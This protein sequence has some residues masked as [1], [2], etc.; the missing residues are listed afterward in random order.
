M[1]LLTITQRAS[2]ALGLP[3]PVAVTG[4]TDIN[5]LQLLELA[6]EEGEE[7]SRRSDWPALTRQQTF[8]TTAAAVQAGALP[9]DWDRFIND[10]LFNR[11]TNRKLIGPLSP[12]DW[13]AE[14]ANPSVS[15]VY[16]AFRLRGADFLI[17]PTPPAGQTIAFE[18][19]TN[20]WCQSSG[21]TA[22]SAWAADTDT[23]ILAER[24]FV[25]G[26]VW[27]FRQAKGLEY[28]EALE[29][30]EQEVQKAAGRAPG[31]G[32]LSL[33]TRPLLRPVIYPNVPDGN[34]P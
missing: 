13:Q 32:V 4:S 20:Q 22:Q 6:Q 31:A 9:S 23:A 25:L 27:R 7:L 2:R 16:D 30:Y 19:V 1:T 14:Q 28:G 3:V 11:T 15:V 29:T 17:T 34:W 26:L 8:T 10:S 21:G 33:S 12:Q 24:L 5:T 18:Y